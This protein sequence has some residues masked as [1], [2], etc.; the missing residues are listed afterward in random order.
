MG[1][2]LSVGGAGRGGFFNRHQENWLAHLRGRKLWLLMPPN[3]TMPGSLA[4][5]HP[6]AISAGLEAHPDL[7]RCVL[8][9][10]EVI[11]LGTNWWHGTCNLDEAVIGL[12]YIGPVDHLPAA[13][14]A[15]A[16]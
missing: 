3:E 4:K 15:A 2:F 7:R 5:Q 8:E 14:Q 13:H 6:C 9:P 10:G 16:L 1:P 12:G 11:Y